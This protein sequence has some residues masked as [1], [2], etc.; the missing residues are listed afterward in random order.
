MRVESAGRAV[1]GDLF[2]KTAV[3]VEKERKAGSKVIDSETRRERGFYVSGRVGESK[4]H[5]LHRGR[6]GF[7]D[8]VTAD[9]DRVPLR[10]LATRPGKQIGHN[11]HGGARRVD[12][13]TAGNVLLED[14]VLDRT[15][16]RS[17][18]GALPPRHHT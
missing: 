13:G 18:I 3:G 2:E 7:A 4:R 12:I 15:G 9:R 6:A 1:F 8:V 11:P 14:V 5:F 10:H 16:K 17:R